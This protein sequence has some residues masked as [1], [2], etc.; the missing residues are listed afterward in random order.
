MFRVHEVEPK[1]PSNRIHA[2]IR[3]G[4]GKG[5]VLQRL[6]A[7]YAADPAKRTDAQKLSAAGQED[8]RQGDGII[9]G[10]PVPQELDQCSTWGSCNNDIASDCASDCS[11]L[12]LPIPRSIQVPGQ[13]RSTSDNTEEY[14]C[15]DSENDQVIDASRLKNNDLLSK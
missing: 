7:A 11:V 15:L 6:P 10:H 4:K 2:G 1:Q 9:N 13:A 12:P 8:F 3:T 14:V 5:A